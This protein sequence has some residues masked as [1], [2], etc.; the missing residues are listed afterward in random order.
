MLKL[1]G[2]SI[3]VTVLLEFAVAGIPA[4]A[5][6][7]K[8]NA[9]ISRQPTVGSEIDRGQEAGFACGLENT[10][11]FLSFTTC[12]DSVVS[13]NKQNSALSEP[14]EF[15]LYVRALQDSFLRKM[16][17][18]SDGHIPLWKD[19]MTKIMKSRHL[20]LKDFCK[21]I[22]AEKCDPA[23][24]AEQTYGNASSHRSSIYEPM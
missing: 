16:A 9:P 18:S 13:S 10:K 15:G 7:S 12:I 1:K 4:G 5:Q 19:R 14:F 20:S 3:I 23:R 24:L 22:N 11:T 8:L 17:L 6:D 2:S 21:A